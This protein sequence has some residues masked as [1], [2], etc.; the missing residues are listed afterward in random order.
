MRLCRSPESFDSGRLTDPD[1]IPF[2]VLIKARGNPGEDCSRFVGPPHLIERQ[3]E[4]LEGNQI[5]RNG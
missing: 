4:K 5:F 1:A 3:T 2:L